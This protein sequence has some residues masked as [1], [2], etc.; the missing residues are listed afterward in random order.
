MINKLKRKLA[1]LLS[2]T[3]AMSLFGSLT[4]SAEGAQAPISTVDGYLDVEV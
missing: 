2:V 4:V 3:V 1:L